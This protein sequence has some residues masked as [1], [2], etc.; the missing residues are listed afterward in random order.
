MKTRNEEINILEI[1]DERIWIHS[2]KLGYG[3]WIPNDK[4]RSL[5]IEKTNELE[6]RSRGGLK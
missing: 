3:H 4:L 2:N 5:L 1:Q 6:K